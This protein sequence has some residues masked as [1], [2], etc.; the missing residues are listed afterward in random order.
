MVQATFQRNPL[1][2]ERTLPSIGHN[3]AKPLEDGQETQKTKRGQE[4]P[5]SEHNGHTLPTP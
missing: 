1:Y 5:Y 3:Q 4:Y 2:H